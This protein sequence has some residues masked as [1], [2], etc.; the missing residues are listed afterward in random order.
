MNIPLISIV[1]LEPMEILLTAV[2]ELDGVNRFSVV[3]PFTYTLVLLPTTLRT[4]YILPA[5]VDGFGKYKV[6]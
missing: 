3:A 4:I 5:H 2:L 1:G 6:L